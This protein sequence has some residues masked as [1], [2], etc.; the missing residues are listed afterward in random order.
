[1][2]TMAQTRA[3][4]DVERYTPLAGVLAVVGWV[5]GMIVIGD[6][7]GKDKGPEILAYYKAHDGR[8]ILGGIIWLIGTALFLWFLGSLRSRLLAAEGPEGRLTSV[9]FAGGVATAIC[10]ALL[11]GPDISGALSEDDLDASAALAI[12]NIVGAFFVGAEYLCPVLLAATA[13]IALRTGALL[14][15]WLVWITLLVA[16]VM[17]IAPIGWAGLVFAFPIWTLIVSYL[18]WRP[19]TTRTLS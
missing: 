15:R 13:L 5:L 7:S 18:L 14:P 1:M 17:L 16:L 12:H 3:G 19:A 9:A 8:I 4:W 10:L 6:I 11:V 2:A